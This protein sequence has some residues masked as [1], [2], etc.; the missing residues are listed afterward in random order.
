MLRDVGTESNSSEPDIRR[1]A[2]QEKN[3]V[4]ADRLADD[5]PLSELAGVTT[6]RLW[7]STA[8]L[9]LLTLHISRGIERTAAPAPIRETPMRILGAPGLLAKRPSDEATANPAQGHRESSD[10]LRAARVRAGLLLVLERVSHGFDIQPFAMLPI[11][12]FGLDTL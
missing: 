7:A 6:E 3:G 9:R 5:R 10:D 1:R 2:H 4:G 11:S 12:V 8:L